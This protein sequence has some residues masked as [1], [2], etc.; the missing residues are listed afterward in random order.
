M[1]LRI[2]GSAA[3]GGFP[4]WNCNCAQCA[5]VRR[6]S[7][8]CT[9]RTQSSVAVSADY[10]SWTIVNAS[11]DIRHQI[12]AFDALHPSVAR[13]SPIEAVLLTDAELDHTA[14]L[15]VLREQ[16]A[17]E[18]HATAQVHD[19]LSRAPPDGTA[20]LSVLSAYCRVAWREAV[21]GV[22]V[23]M[24]GYSY[25]AFDA[26]T[27][28]TP[29]FTGNRHD[30]RGR[31]IGYRFTDNVSGRSVA[32]L[33]AVQELTPSLLDELAGCDCVLIDGTCF[34]DT[35][36]ID[37]GIGRSTSR[38]MGHEPIEA[39]SLDKL[40]ALRVRR[41]IYTHINN[42]NPILLDGSPQREVVRAAGVDVAFDGMEMEI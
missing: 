38:Q 39:G 5:A 9:P 17:I 2:L 3:G 11:P 34:T 14:G 35:E 41:K 1:W 16:D 7:T 22:S 19:V 25:R 28:K 4:Q 36:L 23:L 13:T 30:G 15:L 21:T 27:H 33:P 10:R 29:R 6:Q 20:L 8:R 42:T 31:N 12:D 40:A 32:V 24:P 26:P 18:V 37:Q